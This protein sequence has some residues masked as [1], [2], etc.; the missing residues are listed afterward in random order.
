MDH[1]LG[2]MIEVQKNNGDVA[3]RDSKD[4]EKLSYKFH[5]V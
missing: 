3:M 5:A 4:C 2:Q 1:L